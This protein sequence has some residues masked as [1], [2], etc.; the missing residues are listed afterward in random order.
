[1]TD[2]RKAAEMALEA[3]EMLDRRGGLGLDV[4]EYIRTKIEALRQALAQPE[5]EQKMRIEGSG[6]LTTKPYPDRY[7]SEQEFRRALAEPKR[8]WVGI[9]P[10]EIGQIWANHKEVYGFGIELEQVLKERNT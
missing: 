6:K 10:Q 1:M 2:L 7:E 5:Q 3:L 8:E 4:H 9:E